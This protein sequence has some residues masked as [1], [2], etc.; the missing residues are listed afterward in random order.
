MNF[1]RQT[2]KDMIY[3]SRPVKF[4]EYMSDKYDNV[5][6]ELFKD[7]L[8]KCIA[9]YVEYCKMFKDDIDPR[10][11]FETK[12]EFYRN[13][14]ITEVKAAEYW[15]ASSVIWKTKTFPYRTISLTEAGKTGRFRKDA[16]RGQMSLE[17]WWNNYQKFESKS[18]SN[19]DI[20]GD[21]TNDFK[22]IDL[23]Y[24]RGSAILKSRL[25]DKEIE[26]PFEYLDDTVEI[27][28]SMKLNNTFTHMLSQQ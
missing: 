10:F 17:P 24:V 18:V 23:N 4:S 19:I 20:G 6:R 13:V 28:D 9:D 25:T 21:Q 11:C 15:M 26:V 16:A 27:D 8:E 1:Q 3:D 14:N 2:Y 5:H 12:E 7:A 22:V